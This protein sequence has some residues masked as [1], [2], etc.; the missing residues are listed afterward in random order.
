MSAHNNIILDIYT[1][2]YMKLTM[3]A[4]HESRLSQS[5]PFYLSAVPAG[6]PSPAEDYVD[7]RLD[8]NEY[9][10]KHESA[11]FYCRVAGN[12]MESAGIFN[13]DLLIVDRAIQPQHGSIVIAFINGEITCKILDIKFKQLRAANPLYKPIPINEEMEF[14]IEGV[15]IHSIRTHIS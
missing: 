5:R 12:S 15:V 13:G 11:T 14:C 1:G 6:F 2:F 3:I 7:K 4:Q 9:L 10:I 8:L